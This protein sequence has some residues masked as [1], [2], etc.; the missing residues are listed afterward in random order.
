MGIVRRVGASLD[1]RRVGYGMNALVAWD[2]GKEG[3]EKGERAARFPWVS[4]CYLREV[5]ASTFLRPWPFALYTM[6]HARSEAA[7]A[8]RVE[9]MREALACPA[10][11]LPTVRE[12]KKTRRDLDWSAAK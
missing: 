10:V 1:H 9:E 3:Q 12:L 7:F 8:A 4:H 11:V 5:L 6:L 2:V